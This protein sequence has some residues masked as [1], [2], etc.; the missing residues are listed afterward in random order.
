MKKKLTVFLFVLTLGLNTIFAQSTQVSGT[1]KD[2]NDGTPLPG[3][4]VSIKGTTIGT[5]TDTQGKYSLSVPEGATI[6]IF[7]YIGMETQELNLAGQTTLDVSLES[8]VVGMDEIIILGYTTRKK[9]ELTGSSVQV[10]GE[11]LENNTAS[12]IDQALQGKIA[13]VNISSSSGT[14]GSMQ[15]VRIRGISSVTSGNEPL[16][17]IDG[18][19]VM[20]GDISGNSDYS[21]SLTTQA[22]LNGNDIESITVLKDASATSAYGARGSNGVI[23]I[24]TKSGK[25]GKT[26]FALNTTMGWSNNAVE[27]YKLL[28]TKQRTELYEEAFGEEPSWDQSVNTDWKEL[29]TNKNALQQNY[30]LSAKGG[31]DKGTFYASVGY[32]KNEAMVIHSDFERYNGNISVSR[33]LNQHFTFESKN[34]GSYAEQNGFIETSTYWQNPYATMNL[35]PSHL[36][37]YNDDGS[38]NLFSP[39]NYNS[40]NTLYTMKHNIDQNAVTRIMSNNLVKWDIVEN[41]SFKTNLTLDYSTANYKKYNNPNYGDGSGVNGMLYKFNTLRFNWITQNTLNYKIIQNLHKVDVSVIQEYQKQN[42]DYIWLTKDN[43]STES[44]ISMSSAGSLSEGGGYLEDVYRASYLA[45]I[46]YAFSNKYYV[47]VTFRREGSSKFAKENRFGNFWSIGTAWNVKSE[48]FL[49]EIEELSN[50]RLRASYGVNGNDG[51]GINKYQS[52][53]TYDISYNE[54]GA[55]YASQ[56]GN[57]DLS[58]EKNKIADLGLEFGFFNNHIS[59]GVGYYN[60]NTYDLLLDVPLSLTSGFEEQVRNVGEMNNHGFEFELNFDVFRTADFSW[61]IGGNLATVKNEVTSLNKDTE[62]NY[63]TIS[64]T[65]RQVEVGHPVYAWYMRKWAG[66]DPDTGNPLWYVNGKNG[67]TTGTWSEAQEEYQG[68]SALPTYTGNI[69]TH[70][71]YKGIFLNANLYFSGGN[72]IYD[73]FSYK[74]YHPFYTIQGSGVQYQGVASLMDRWQQPGDVT[75]QPRL[76]YDD[77]LLASAYESSRFLYDGDYVRLKEVTLGYNLPASITSK[78]KCSRITAYVKGINLLTWVKDDRMEFDPEVN[79]LGIHKLSTPPPT[80]SFIVGLN[81]NF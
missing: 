75:D 40:Y 20:S 21:A 32:N 76:G 65:Y 79:Y 25:A 44:L 42:I 37:A 2:A 70:L 64:D 5:I 54:N 63:K 12:S 1:V 27:G 26:Q 7:S 55:A 34:S 51:I 81:F 49:Q 66:V 62:G 10:S 6:L 38:L 13:G 4:S 59:G 19:P 23:V 30:N 50:L 29:L 60:R 58:W 61:S 45:L 16:Y 22:T 33:K 35:L 53:L 71:E 11:E 41:L 48:S 14:P 15:N 68:G 24:T 72:K 9:N 78:I 43:F 31:S 36:K 47:D 74:L 18:V 17:V 57:S 77:E 80:K 52:L 56:Y 46:N 39:S 8:N 73:R 69:N 28:N 67:E 3:V